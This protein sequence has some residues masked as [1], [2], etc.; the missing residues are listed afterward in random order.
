MRSIETAFATEAFPLET[1]K[2]QAPAPDPLFQALQAQAAKDQLVADQEHARG[3]QAALLARYGFRLA[4]A[5]TNSSP[6]RGA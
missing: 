5:G 1:N 4:L 6:M 3:E 2:P